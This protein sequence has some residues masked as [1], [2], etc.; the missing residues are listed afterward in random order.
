MKTINIHGIDIK[1]TKER[2]D[3]LIGGWEF[4]RVQSML[5]NIK[6][7]DTIFDIGA[8]QGDI[9]A[10]LAKKAKGKTVAFEPSPVMWPH[11]KSNFENN[12]LK[13]DG[14]HCGFASDVTEMNPKNLNY[15]DTDKNG[16]PL[17]AYEKKADVRAF[18]HL[19]EEA[20][21]TRQI[22]LDDYCKE[23]NI[24]PNLITID[25]EGSEYNV[26]KG[27]M[28]VLNTSMPLVYISVHYDFMYTKFKK[29]FNDLYH[30]T[31][32]KAGYKMKFLG[33]D[34]EAHFVFYK[35]SILEIREIL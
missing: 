21:A 3:L 15:D 29:H 6:E 9:T 13:L 32:E 22:T 1:L 19:D 8:E 35:K 33:Q 12:G 20:S 11:I 5:L 17:L 23:H 4:A 24:Y 27:A 30:D 14:Y 2:A 18:R 31:F 7:G 25:V 28:E 10:L 34:H 16:Y 26:M